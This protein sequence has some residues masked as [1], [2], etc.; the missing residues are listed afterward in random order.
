V[1]VTDLK[2]PPAFAS[3]WRER[4]RGEPLQALGRCPWSRDVVLNPRLG[5]AVPVTNGLRR[6]E[7][8]AEG[9]L[10]REPRGP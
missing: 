3:A 5:P 1:P 9:T 7:T 6:K 4:L 2:R 10:R 8:L